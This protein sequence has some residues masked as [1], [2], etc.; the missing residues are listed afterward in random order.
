M[1]II[2][3]CLRFIGLDRL[4]SYRR[5]V[6]GQWVKRDASFDSLHD[7]WEHVPDGSFVEESYPNAD[8]YCSPIL[9]VEIWPTR[10]PKVE[11]RRKAI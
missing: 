7:T 3:R 6:G 1:T 8:A 5:W 11:L 10:L 4:Q 2:Q 9:T